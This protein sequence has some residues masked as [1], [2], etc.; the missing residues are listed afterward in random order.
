MNT[1]SLQAL[2]I[3]VGLISFQNFSGI[4][5]VLF[6]SETIFNKAGN[7]LDPAVA[8][9]LIGITMFV[10]SSIS[11]A[12]VDRSGRRG[13]LLAS[14]GGMAASL[15]AMGIYFFLDERNMANSLGWLPVTS[16]IAFILFYCVGFGPLPFT[17]LGEM[18]SPEIKSMASSIAIA[19]GWIV[20]FGV[21]KAFLP[22]ESVVGNYGSFWIFGGFCVLA[23]VFTAKLVFETKGLTLNEIQDRLN[24]R[25]VKK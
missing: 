12:F 22:L 23:V 17:M 7:S 15:T 25:K 10:A 13:L 4:D 11:S 5:A 19:A 2:T 6:Y 9:I 20:D 1:F 18:L 14:A 16:L 24:R 21:T 8:T 3:V